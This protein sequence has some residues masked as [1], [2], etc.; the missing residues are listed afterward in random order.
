MFDVQARRFDEPIVV[1]DLEAR[2]R[3]AEEVAVVGAA[4]LAE[5]VLVVAAAGEWSELGQ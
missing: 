4:L 2:A 5:P 3:I 1:P